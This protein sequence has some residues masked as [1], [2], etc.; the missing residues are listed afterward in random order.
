MYKYVYKAIGPPPIPP[1]KSIYD[2]MEFHMSHRRD[3]VTSFVFV[4]VYRYIS[5]YKYVYKATGPPPILPRKSIYDKIEFHMS[6]R[7]DSVTSFVFVF[8]FVIT[9][10][11]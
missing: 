9:N 7:R 5:M 3:G 11:I 1:R 10:H 6:H 4:F 8:V 2:K